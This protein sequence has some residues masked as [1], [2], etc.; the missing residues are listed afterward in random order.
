MYLAIKFND[1]CRIPEKLKLITIKAIKVAINESKQSDI[2]TLFLTTKKSYNLKYEIVNIIWHYNLI[3]RE[4]NNDYF[5][6]LDNKSLIDES[7]YSVSF[8]KFINLY[9]FA[10]LTDSLV[11]KVALQATI[12]LGLNESLVV[13][14]DL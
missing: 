14:R 4:L 9:E 6:G 10:Y 1:K 2:P 13:R 12:I 3:L 5:P 7:T 8:K 11:T